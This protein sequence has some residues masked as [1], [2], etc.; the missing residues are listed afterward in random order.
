MNHDLSVARYFS[1]RYTYG[2]RREPQHFGNLGRSPLSLMRKRQ[3]TE[4]RT[5]LGNFAEAT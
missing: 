4:S 3:T 1:S 2:S 5:A